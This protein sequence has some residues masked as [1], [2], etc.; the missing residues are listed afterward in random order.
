MKYYPNPKKV[1]IQKGDTTFVPERVLML[2]GYMAIGIDELQKVCS[3]FYYS[4]NENSIKI[5]Y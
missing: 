2:N 5:E 4:L 3:S 1:V